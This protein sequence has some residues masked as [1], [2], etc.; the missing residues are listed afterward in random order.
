MEKYLHKPVV[1]EAIQVSEA[2]IDELVKMFP[3]FI[4]PVRGSLNHL[5]EAWSDDG[6][7]SLS[8]GDWIIKEG[9]KL[10]SCKNIKFKTYYT[11][12]EEYKETVG[13]LASLLSQIE[14][15]K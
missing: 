1:V 10:L 7:V 3:N 14:P 4:K 12:L 5:V 9:A 6:V 8:P 2:N 11:S 13:E 15:K